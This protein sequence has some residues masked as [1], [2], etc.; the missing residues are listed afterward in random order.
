MGRHSYQCMLGV[1][2]AWHLAHVGP[3]RLCQV[4][5]RME[6]CPILSLQ[7]IAWCSLGPPGARPMLVCALPG[8][9]GS[10]IP[11]SL[12][13]STLDSSSFPILIPPLWRD[14]ERADLPVLAL[15]WSPRASLPGLLSLETVYSQPFGFGR[16]AGVSF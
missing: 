3:F 9:T 15:S 11:R 1:S 13:F 16:L 8:A 12:P 2:R 7:L 6:F 14:P 4:C 10:Q 5:S